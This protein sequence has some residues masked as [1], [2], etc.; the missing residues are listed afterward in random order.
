LQLDT[1]LSAA[2]RGHLATLLRKRFMGAS[3]LKENP[4]L[5][6]ATMVDPRFKSG[7]FLEGE[8]TH[9][10]SHFQ[11][12]LRNEV[13]RIARLHLSSQPAQAAA[14]QQVNSCM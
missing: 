14:R 7:L 5:L 3:E 11:E 12:A 10:L 9:L 13:V 6:A 8:F 4:V 1:A 2:P